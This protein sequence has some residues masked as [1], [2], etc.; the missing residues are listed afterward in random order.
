MAFYY[1]KAP[2]FADQDSRRLDAARRV[3]DPQRIARINQQGR[4]DS[5]PHLGRVAI[6]PSSGER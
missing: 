2:A 6:E 4:V 1:R 3:A 5:L